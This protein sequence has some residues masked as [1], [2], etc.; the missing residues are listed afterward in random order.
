MTISLLLVQVVNPAPNI[1]NQLALILLIQH[2][3]VIHHHVI[4]HQVLVKRVSANA[5]LAILILATLI[6]AVLAIQQTLIILE[7]AILITT[8]IHV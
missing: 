7:H 8:V 6:L 4:H 1:A 3:H 2:H 5:I